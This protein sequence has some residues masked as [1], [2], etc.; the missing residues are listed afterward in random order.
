MP[1]QPWQCPV[2]E[3]NC[4]G[5]ED[6]CKLSVT[7]KRQFNFLLAWKP[8]ASKTTL[9]DRPGTSSFGTFSETNQHRTVSVWTKCIVSSNVKSTW[10]WVPCLFIALAISV[11]ERNRER[12]WE[13]KQNMWC[14]GFAL[15]RLGMAW[16]RRCCSLA[17][18]EWRCRQ[19]WGFLGKWQPT[20]RDQARLPCCDEF[21]YWRFVTHL[22]VDAA[23][24][25]AK[26][27]TLVWASIQTDR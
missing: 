14:F 6:I 7:M 22:C 18:T 24:T 5:V 16:R 25:I 21:W 4:D 17:Q 27:R 12:E 9:P 23:V 19:W 15:L 26:E 3:W 10:F 2:E 1:W 13:R 20:S 11:E 8:A